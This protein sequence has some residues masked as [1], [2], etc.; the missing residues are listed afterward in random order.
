MTPLQAALILITLVTVRLVLPAVLTLMFG[1][2]ID[3]FGV[4]L[5]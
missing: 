1:R 5:S 2:F 4:Q 3:R